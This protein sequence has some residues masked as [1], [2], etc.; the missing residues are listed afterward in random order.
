MNSTEWLLRSV[1]SV[2]KGLQF[3]RNDLASTAPAKVSRPAV[4][5]VSAAISTDPIK[6]NGR[7]TRERLKA[8]LKHKEETW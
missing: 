3:K 1:Q 7:S 8:V 6:P 2:S 5:S 4:A